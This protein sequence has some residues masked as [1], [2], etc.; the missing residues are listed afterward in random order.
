MKRANVADL[1]KDPGSR[2]SLTTSTTFVER[3]FYKTVWG[4]PESEEWKKTTLAR[5]G[6]AIGIATGSLCR[7]P[8]YRRRCCWRG[9]HRCTCHRWRFSRTACS[10]DSKKIRSCSCSRNL[11][12]LSQKHTASSIRIALGSRSI[13]LRSRTHAATQ[14]TELGHPRPGS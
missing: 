10:A 4:M 8:R 2:G 11:G 6:P 12:H 9:C 7:R 13:H 14:R 5:I 3:S 1:V